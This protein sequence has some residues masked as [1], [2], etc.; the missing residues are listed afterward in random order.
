[1]RKDSEDMATKGV[2][3]WLFSTTSLLVDASSHENP[4]E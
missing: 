2:E 3:N 1:M 4:N